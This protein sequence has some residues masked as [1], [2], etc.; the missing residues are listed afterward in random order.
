VCVFCVLLT[1]TLA[2]MRHV[3]LD[4]KST[5]MRVCYVL[6]VLLTSTLAMMGHV[7]LD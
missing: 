3:A 2:M 6:C 4:K 7:A 5:G 1:S